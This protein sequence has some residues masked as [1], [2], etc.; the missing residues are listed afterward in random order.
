M[1][2]LDFGNTL[3]LKYAS[4][5]N[6]GS[7]WRILCATGVFLF[8]LFLSVSFFRVAP[9]S[10]CPWMTKWTWILI[11]WPRFD[12]ALF[13]QPCCTI[14]RTKILMDNYLGKVFW[15]KKFVIFFI[16]FSFHFGKTK[17]AYFHFFSSMDLHAMP[18]A[19]FDEISAENLNGVWCDEFAKFLWIGQYFSR[20]KRGSEKDPPTA[21][22]HCHGISQ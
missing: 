6:L 4:E 1:F 20:P 2:S 17:S 11:F 18:D 15:W 12:L 22:F 13:G 21:I 7:S 14:K 10:F 8:S 16:L 9:L 5:Y 3:T 19:I